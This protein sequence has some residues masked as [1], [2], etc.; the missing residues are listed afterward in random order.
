[1]RE[2]KPS[3]TA[4]A[5]HAAP[6]QEAS[7]AVLVRAV[8]LFIDFVFSSLIGSAAKQVREKKPSHTAATQQ[9]APD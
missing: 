6:D 3:H 5:Q 9:A 4:A 1:V 8:V 7:E 2:K